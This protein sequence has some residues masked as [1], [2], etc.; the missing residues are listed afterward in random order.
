MRKRATKHTQLCKVSNAVW[1]RIKTIVAANKF[2]KSSQLSYGVWKGCE[3]VASTLQGSQIGEVCQRTRNSCDP[4]V[5]KIKR[6]KLSQL[7]NSVWQAGQLVA[8]TLERS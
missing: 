1:Q 2:L 5:R 4:I 8:R 3:L 7:P 6:T